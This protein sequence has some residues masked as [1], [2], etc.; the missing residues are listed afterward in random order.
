MCAHNG[1]LYSSGWDCCIKIW[2]GKT[3]DLINSV[4][5]SPLG[6]CWSMTVRHPPNRRGSSSQAAVA[7]AEAGTRGVLAANTTSLVCGVR[8]SDV[9]IRDLSDDNLNVVSSMHQNKWA[10]K[11]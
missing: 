9:E 3:L 10:S 2:N 5:I 1:K 4:S 11:R 8:D 6:V 7:A